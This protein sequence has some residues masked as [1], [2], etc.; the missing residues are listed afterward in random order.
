MPA[1]P[2]VVRESFLNAFKPFP[3]GLRPEILSER[4]GLTTDA[5]KEIRAGLSAD[6]FRFSE[7]EDGRWNLADAPDALYPYWIR[8]GLNCDRL[9]RQIYYRAEVESTQDIAFEL[10]VEGRP[11]GTIVVADHQTGGRGRGSR[12]WYST[13][14]QSLLFSVLLDL[15]PPDTFASVL[16]VAIATSLARAIQDVAD[17]PARIKFPNDI[18]VRG[19]KVAGILLE[20]RDYGVP[21]PR[22]VA[23]VGINVNQLPEEIPEPVRDS[24]TS[25]R[26][27]RRDREPILRARLLRATLRELEKWLDQI[28]Q[29]HYDDLENA[30]NRYSA[31]EGRELRFRAGGGEELSGR[32]VDA[33]IRQGLLIRLA[34]GEERRYRL[35]HLNDVRFL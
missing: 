5:L 18:L 24:A 19:R 16:T 17:L 29:G 28:R 6:G 30:W 35:E 32:V 4:L 3:Q 21:P 31:M 7:D 34:S 25:L 26:A 15:E 8:A 27:E 14:G 22:A 10:M 23:G 20:V 1:S 11:H 12:Q 13:P 33:S 2:D 9:A